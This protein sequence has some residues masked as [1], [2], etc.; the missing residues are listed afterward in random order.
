M[1]RTDELKRRA[2]RVAYL[3]EAWLM[4]HKLFM[5]LFMVTVLA[6]LVAGEKGGSLAEIRFFW[7]WK[8]GRR[9]IALS[10]RQA[11]LTYQRLLKTL[12]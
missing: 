10:P 2:V 5:F 3:V 8:F 12:A 11:T 4:S 6:A 1:N 7:L 9:E